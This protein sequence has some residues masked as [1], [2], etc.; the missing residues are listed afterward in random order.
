MENIQIS[1]NKLS[2]HG[3]LLETIRSDAAQKEYAH[4]LYNNRFYRVC[5]Q[6]SGEIIFSVRIPKNYLSEYA[7]YRINN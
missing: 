1:V 3:K 7:K 4:Y 6:M 2:T 5:K